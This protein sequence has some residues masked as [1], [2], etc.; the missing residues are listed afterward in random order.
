MHAR[1]GNFQANCRGF[2]GW[3]FDE[4]KE[5]IVL[6]IHMFPAATFTLKLFVIADLNWAM[7]QTVRFIFPQVKSFFFEQCVINTGP[8]S[9]TLL[10]YGLGRSHLHK[11]SASL[12]VDEGR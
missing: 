3:R 2:Q 9:L 1:F 8:V 5:T 7:I 12:E 11:M 4:L 10:V 6:L